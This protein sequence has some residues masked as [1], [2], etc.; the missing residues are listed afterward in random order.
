MTLAAIRLLYFDTLGHLHEMS[1][2]D[3]IFICIANHLLNYG[4]IQIHENLQKDIEPA[5]E[6]IFTDYL[7]RLLKGEPLQYILRFTEFYNLRIRVD[8]RVLIPR[9]ETEFMVDRIVKESQQQSGLQMIDLC[10]GSGCIA[11]ALAKA[12]KNLSVTAMDVSEDAL[13]LAYLNAKENHTEILFVHDDLLNLQETYSLY[14]L[15]VSNPPYVREMEKKSMH[16]NVLDFEPEMALFVPDTDP[17]VFYRAIAEFGIKHLA[18]NGKVYTE[19][20]EH[21]GIETKS[22]FQTKGYKKVD[23]YKDIRQKDRYLIAQL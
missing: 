17:L 19:I 4:K 20:N 23:I 15:I 1:E 6:K 2:I 10:T 13:E 21:L 9:P 22:I 11:I 14:D 16:I 3:S 7:N 8:P 18:K 12:L 5:N